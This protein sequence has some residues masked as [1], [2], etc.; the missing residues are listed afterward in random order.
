MRGAKLLLVEDHEVN[1]QVATELLQHE[2]FWVET[3]HDGRAA[4][5]LLRDAGEQAF[6]LV[7]MDL[8]MPEMD[9]Y[10]ATQEIRQFGYHALP[11]VAMTADA[12]SGVA[13]RCFDVGMNDYVTKPIDPQELFS[14]LARWIT[15]GVRPLYHPAQTPAEDAAAL[16]NLP[17]IDVASGIER[18]GGNLDAYRKLLQKF[19]QQYA[20][21]GEQ[22]HAALMRDNLESAIHLAHSLKGVSGNIGAMALHLAARDVELTL[23][24]PHQPGLS[25]KLETM[26]SALHQVIQTLA[27]LANTPTVSPATPTSRPIDAAALRPM[28]AR[29]R[30]LLQE[31]DMEAVECV[32]ALK[33]Q[34]SGTKIADE[35]QKIDTAL[36]RYDFEQALAH[37]EQLISQ[38]PHD[39]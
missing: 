11:I 3:A 13:E 34:T 16:P 19:A 4:V 39:L 23:K 17:G 27:P 36:G 28:I 38:M 33:Q 35:L 9:G 31:D 1:R 12:M 30:A 7:L 14:A 21:Y 8:Q 26:I 29:L 37:L 5:T 2:G 6:D 24:D 22:I 15:P 18:I 10:T 32:E 25:G 20:A